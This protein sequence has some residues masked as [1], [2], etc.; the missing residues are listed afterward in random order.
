MHVCI[1]KPS[2]ILS[3]KQEKLRDERRVFYSARI[4]G[5]IDG[6]RAI[7]LGSGTSEPIKIL[8]C[9]NKF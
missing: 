7:A 2:I 3:R 8:V 9:E 1:Y 4:S 6:K 5:V